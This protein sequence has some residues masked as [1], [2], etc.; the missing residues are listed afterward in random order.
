[1]MDNNRRKG[2]YTDMYDW[3]TLLDGRIWH[4]IVNQVNFYI[5]KMRILIKSSLYAASHKGDGVHMSFEGRMHITGT[6]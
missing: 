2:R 1:M 4:N 3:G 6:K 5:K